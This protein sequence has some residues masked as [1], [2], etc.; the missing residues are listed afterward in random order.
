MAMTEAARKK[1]AEK[2][3]DLQIEIAPQLAKMDELKDQLRAAAIEGK[4][5]FTDEVAGKGTVEV[6]AERK[7]QFK[8]L[9]PMLVAEVYLALKDAARKKLHD[10]G[11]VEDKKIFT[12]G[13]K[14]SVTV[15]L[16]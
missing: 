4:A 10:D 15:R 12:K 3:V 13:A 8:G 1:L 9:M 2:L 14:P 7:A 11:L 16:A 5:G 6:S